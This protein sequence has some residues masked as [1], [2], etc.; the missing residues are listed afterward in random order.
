[1]DLKSG[2]KSA[3]TTA[4]GDSQ[5]IDGFAAAAWLSNGKGISER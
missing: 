5:C 1:M 3:T 4:T 2:N